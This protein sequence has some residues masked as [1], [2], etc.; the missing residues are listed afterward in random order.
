M[1]DLDLQ[2]HQKVVIVL[3]SGL[4]FWMMMIKIYF[5]IE[6]TKHRQKENFAALVQKTER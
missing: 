5:Q 4:Y 3:I 2:D 6:N 1:S